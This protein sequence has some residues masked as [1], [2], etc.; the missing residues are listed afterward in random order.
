MTFRMSLAASIFPRSRLIRL[1][2]DGVAGQF[3]L[4]QLMVIRSLTSVTPGADQA[5]F[6]A[7][8]RS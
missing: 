8:V 5:V 7:N 3:A 4:V 6:S 2:R 1:L